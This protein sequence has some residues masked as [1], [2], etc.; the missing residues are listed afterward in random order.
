MHFQ[1]PAVGRDSYARGR[2]P[3]D[4]PHE[5][6]AGK[7]G[8]EL[9]VSSIIGDREQNGT[10]DS[11]GVSTDSAN[12]YDVISREAGL[13][14]FTHGDGGEHV[15]PAQRNSGMLQRHSVP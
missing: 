13:M 9:F 2:A 12:R 4:R 5:R 7:A 15:G 1:Q 11:R 8:Q 10:I 6:E 14:G 3:E